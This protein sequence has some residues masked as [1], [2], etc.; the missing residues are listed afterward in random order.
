MADN[1]R[2]QVLRRAIE[3]CVA[4]DVAPLPELFTTDVRG[5][6]PHMMVKSLDELK[7]AVVERED[8]LSN[9]ELEINGLDVHG[10]KGFAEYRVQALFSEPLKV[11]DETVLDPNGRK[12]VVGAALIAEFDGDKISTFRNYFDDASLLEQLVAP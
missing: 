9:I 11:D 10:N 8:A 1:G 7:Q 5:W 2:G 4:G 3:A 12:I 6:G